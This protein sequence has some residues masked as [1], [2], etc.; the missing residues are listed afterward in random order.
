MLD[1]LG[2]LAGGQ[3]RLWRRDGRAL[4]LAAGSDP[5]SASR[6][7]YGA[8]FGIVQR[9]AMMQ[10]FNDVFMFLAYMFAAMLPL[11]LIM[12]RPKHMQKSIG[13]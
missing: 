4:K 12:R 10:S 3:V 11:I 8:L 5:V 1:S 7:A 2:A 6:Q 13:H 9:Q